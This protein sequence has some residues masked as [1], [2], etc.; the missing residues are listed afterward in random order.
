MSTEGGKRICLFGGTFDPIHTAH[1]RVASEA[2]KQYKLDEILFVP[3]ANPPHK[4]SETLTDFADRFRM[5]EIA[6]EGHPAFRVSR[7]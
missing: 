6:C 3:A 1:L 5:V 4:D 7:L 2:V